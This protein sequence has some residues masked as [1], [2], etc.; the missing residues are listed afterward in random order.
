M[1]SDGD[2]LASSLV[3]LFT[4]ADLRA[5]VKQLDAT[6]PARQTIPPVVAAELDAMRRAS[7]Q[8]RPDGDEANRRLWHAF[9]LACDEDEAA[10]A[11]ELANLFADNYDDRDRGSGGGYLLPQASV[12]W[13]GYAARAGDD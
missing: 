9:E 1:T 4:T 12:W 13:T 11:D 8:P 6:G 10:M 7:C 5:R 3:R 2:T